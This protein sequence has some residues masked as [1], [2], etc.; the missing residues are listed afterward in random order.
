MIAEPHN[1]PNPFRQ[2]TTF[3]YELSRYVDRV[4]IHIYTQSG[5][6][7]RRLDDVPTRQGYN[8]TVW[9]GQDQE[10]RILP[11]GIYFYTVSAEDRNESFQVYSRL[12]ILR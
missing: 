3:V 6:L 1:H 11:N 9:D 5:R 7:I 2:R 10:G 12:A 8:E 4:E